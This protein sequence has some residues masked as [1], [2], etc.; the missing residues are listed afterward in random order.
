MFIVVVPVAAPI[1]KSVAAPPKLIVVAVVSIKLNVVSSVAIVPPF[2]LIVLATLS[3]LPTLILPPV[4]NKPV[5]IVNVPVPPILIPSPFEN[6][7]SP[8]L[9]PV[10]LP[11]VILR[12]P[13]SLNP[14]LTQLLLRYVCPRYCPLVGFS[15]NFQSPVSPTVV[16]VGTVANTSMFLDASPV[17]PI[18]MSAAVNLP[19]TAASLRTLNLPLKS[20]SSV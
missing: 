13:V 17:I 9:S 20:D 15:C 10:P 19:S 6:V 14:N 18:V 16:P 2:A 12:L 8:V 5:P 4:D 3:M 1:C 11:P 7:K